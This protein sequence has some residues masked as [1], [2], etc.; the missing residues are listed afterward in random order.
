[1]KK[2]KKEITAE[3]QKPIPLAIRRLFRAT[4]DPYIIG[5]QPLL[6]PTQNAYISFLFGF[7]VRPKSTKQIADQRGENTHTIAEI[8]ESGLAKL[9]QYMLTNDSNVILF[10]SHVEQQV[11]TGRAS[12]GLMSFALAIGCEDVPGLRERF[13]AVRPQTPAKRMRRTKPAG[14]LRP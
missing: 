1:M 8:I 3:I 12:Y 2:V 7:G 4:T 10:K 14:K 11:R 13:D 5:E 6:T 9:K